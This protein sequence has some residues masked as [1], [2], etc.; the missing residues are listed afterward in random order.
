MNLINF[1]DVTEGI[2]LM[3][4]ISGEFDLTVCE[5]RLELFLQI[6]FCLAGTIRDNIRFGVP[7]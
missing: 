6:L 3:V 7:D 2:S 1:Y 4:E 5:A